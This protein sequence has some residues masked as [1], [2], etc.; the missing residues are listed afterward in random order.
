MTNPITKNTYTGDGSTALFSFTFPYIQESDVKVFLDNVQQTILTEYEFSNA[1]TI[2]FLTP[3]AMG[4]EIVIAR[5]TT[6]DDLKATFFPGSAIRARDLNDNF[7][8]NLYVVQENAQD[9]TDATAAAE[10]AQR[11]AEQAAADAAIATEANTKADQALAGVSTAQT[12][13][14]NAQNSA[15]SAQQSANSAAADASQAQSD[16]SAALEAAQNAENAVQNGP[17]LS[18]NGQSGAV[19][20]SAADVGA[21]TTAQGA[22]ADT[23]LQPAA[24]GTTVQAYDANNVVSDVAPTFTAT[25]QTTERII[26]GTFDLATGNHWTCGAITVPNPINCVTGVS[27][28]IR[29]TAGPVV[30]SSYFRFPGGAAPTIASFPAV[31]PFYV[32]DAAT[33]LMGNVAEGIS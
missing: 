32:Q 2:G 21:A 1:T 33:I 9:A 24:I 27:G 4:V 28:L 6:Y 15:N 13:A 11:A 18:V 31:I 23:S 19:N 10:A 26:T 20:L 5:Q 22:L 25:V 30:W 8:Q 29:I 17:V 12:A 7:V 16:A 14:I 3:P